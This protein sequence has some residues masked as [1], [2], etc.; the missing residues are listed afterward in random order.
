MNEVNA[1]ATRLQGSCLC[2]AVAYRVETRLKNFYFCHCQQCRKL[3]G[4]AHA[5]N[6][7][8]EPSSVEWCRGGDKIKRYDAPDD[9]S[10]THVFCQEC[11][12]G[13]PFMNTSKTTLFIP[14]GSLDTEAGIEVD[15]NIFW[16][17]V[18]SWYRSALTARRCEAFP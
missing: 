12:S 6:I 2:G 8:A 17:E 3:T 5:A 16:E 14:A 9:R 13:L 7:L 15:C 4:S 18:P 11:G 10:F 1:E